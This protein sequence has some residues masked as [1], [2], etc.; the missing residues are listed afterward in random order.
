MQVF[1]ELKI[2]QD[3]I[4]AL[5]LV[6]PRSLI[7]FLF[8]QISFGQILNPGIATSHFGSAVS[9]Y[10]TQIAVGASQTDV[11]SFSQVGEV[12]IF[13]LNGNDWDVQPPILPKP[14][15]QGLQFGASV[16]VF[17]NNLIIG[18]PYSNNSSG[19]FLLVY[20]NLF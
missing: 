18:T 14:I 7:T 2:L 3:G 12:F 1:P 10:Q 20:E 5:G 13:E 4:M 17:G 6:L 19:N 9:I 8:F 15:V 11:N 16:S